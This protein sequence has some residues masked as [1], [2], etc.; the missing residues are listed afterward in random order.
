MIG[1]PQSTLAVEL[2]IDDPLITQCTVGVDTE[3]MSILLS[4]VC[5][6]VTGSA[7]YGTMGSYNGLSWHPK[8]RGTVPAS[9]GMPFA[10][11][12]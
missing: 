11:L 2:S 3:L 9:V 6:N 5:V 7:A 4:S 10:T 12:V 8:L 1:P